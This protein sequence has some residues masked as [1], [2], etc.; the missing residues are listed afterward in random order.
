MVLLMMVYP[1]LQTAYFSVSKVTLP[2]LNT[3]FVGLRN[4]L[5]AFADPTTGPTAWR[6][7]VWVVVTVVSRFVLGLAAALVFHATVRGT[8]WMRVLA[9]IPWTVPS[10]VGANLWRWMLQADSGAINE[11][12]RYV[13]LSDFALNWLGNPNLTLFSVSVAY[14]WAGYPFVMLLLLAGLQ[15]I[16]KEYIEAAQCDGAGPLRVFRYV[17][18][19]SLAGIIGIAIVLEIIS[20][21]NTFDTLYVIAGGGPAEATTI[22]G[23]AVFNAVFADF[24]Y[25]GASA[26]SMLLLVATATLFLM[27]SAGRSA[28]ARSRVGH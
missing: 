2:L 28:V 8:V 14:T 6:T 13:G 18:L 22:W 1:V 9:F 19:P 7:L 5:D 3:T 23:L 16:P 24:N 4:Y 21:L 17:T 20:A 11:A 26:L 12:L 10:V 27:Y 15:G 25:G